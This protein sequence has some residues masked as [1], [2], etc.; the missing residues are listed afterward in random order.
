MAHGKIS[1]QKNRERRKLEKMSARRAKKDAYAAMALSGNNRK[2]KGAEKTSDGLAKDFK[3]PSLSA[4]LARPA[5]GKPPGWINRKA[6]LLDLLPVPALAGL[7]LY[8]YAV[9]LGISTLGLVK[10]A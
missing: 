7:G 4:V 1:R 3:R 5:I 2:A 8:G 9:K 6:V 10:V